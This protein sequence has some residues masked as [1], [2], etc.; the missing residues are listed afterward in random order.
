MAADAEKHHYRPTESQFK[1]KADEM[2]VTYDLEQKTRGD[3]H[4]L[5]PKVKR[6]YIAGDVQDWHV[7][8]VKKRSGR[9]V[10]GVTIEYEQSRSGYRRKEYTAKRGE[11]VYKVPPTKVKASSQKFRKVVELPKDA[12]NVHF[13]KDASK[14][15]K[16]Y[17]QALQDVR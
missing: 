3:G 10:Y 1:G 11:T 2:Y 14:L 9:E 17:R 16:K 6:V 4:A 8:K 5:Y 7:G 12:Q 15:P 13:Y